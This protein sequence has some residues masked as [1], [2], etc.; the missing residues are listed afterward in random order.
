MAKKIFLLSFFFLFFVL[1]KNSFAGTVKT[2]NYRTDKI[3]TVYC[4]PGFSTD[5][6]FKS[7]IIAFALGD[8]VRWVA[9]PV[10]NNLFV[11]PIQKHLE[12][13]LS[14]ITQN[15]T[16]EF[17]LSSQKNSFYQLVNFRQPEKLATVLAN[18]LEL[19][20][21]KKHQ[22]FNTGVKKL[23]PQEI[24]K[25]KFGYTVS[26]NKSI[27]PLQVFSFNGFVYI[28]MPKKLQSMPAFFVMSAG[29]LDLINYIV[30]GRYIIVERLFTKGALKLEN[31][32]AFIYKKQHNSGGFK[33]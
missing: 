30:R 5:F 10:I 1:I 11:K 31:K 21:K 13:S 18:K 19:N 28:Y 17:T 22:I 20:L 6:K 3:Y 4:R 27:R 33:W 24:S 12:T 7:K 23:T 8:T 2:F 9:Q 15:K 26:G 25:I 29:H 14:I 16:Y 32:E